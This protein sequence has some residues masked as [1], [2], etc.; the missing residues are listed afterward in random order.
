[1]TKVLLTKTYKA[2]E[3]GKKPRIPVA[4]RHVWDWFWR[5]DRTREGTGYGI[6]PLQPAQI[7]AWAKLRHIHLMPWHLDAI[8]RM[9][10]TRMRVYFEKKDEASKEPD[11]VQVSTRPLTSRLFDALFPSKR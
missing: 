8:E 7:D 2:R 9:D 5:M 10:A 3:P 6:N 11:K 1:M 4:G